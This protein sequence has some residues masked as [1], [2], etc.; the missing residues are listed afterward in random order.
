MRLEEIVLNYGIKKVDY[1]DNLD[2]E[3]G[4]VDDHEDGIKPVIEL[5]EKEN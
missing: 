3:V 2:D 1:F 5:H 4:I